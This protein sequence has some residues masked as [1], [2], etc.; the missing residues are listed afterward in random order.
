M[1]LSSRYLELGKVQYAQ[2]EAIYSYSPVL[3][4][5]IAVITYLKLIF[6]PDKLTLYH[7]EFFSYWQVAWYSLL[8]IIFLWITIWFLRKNKI[9]AFWLIFFL[10]ALL[11]TTLPFNVAS[12]IAERY[13]YLASIGIIV[14]LTY[15]FKHLYDKRRYR[16]FS[17][18]FFLIIVI[19]LSVRTIWRNND[20]R[21]Y[22]SFWLSTVKTSPLSYQAHNNAGIVY[23]RHGKI[24]LAIAEFEKSAA[25]VPNMPQN[26][27]NIGSLFASQGAKEK[28]I[29]YFEK[30]LQYDPEN[31]KLKEVLKKLKGEN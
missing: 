30:A 28:A 10:I 19:V 6:W 1:Q 21:T 27:L 18:F 2:Q 13:A 11:P 22:E 9:I 20:W 7:S 15:G 14:P 8:L 25:I 17:F 29:K 16:D 12:S 5:P 3:Q 31:E 23:A 24:A 4:V 26:Y